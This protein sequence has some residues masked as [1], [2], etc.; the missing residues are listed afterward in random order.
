M[1]GAKRIPGF[2]DELG[3]HYRRGALYYEMVNSLFGGI[4]LETFVYKEI[5]GFV[6]SV[7]TKSGEDMAFSGFL[8]IGSKLTSDPK[9][10]RQVAIWTRD[11]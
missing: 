8:A 2:F 7:R 3:L 10:S 6:Q 5:G 4:I 1:A 9:R 11:C